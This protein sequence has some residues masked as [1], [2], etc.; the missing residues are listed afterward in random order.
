GGSELWTSDGTPAGTGQV[1]DINAGGA[2]SN[3]GIL[4]NVNGLLYFSADDGASGR[5]LWQSDGTLAGTVTVR[6]IYPGPTGSDPAFLVGMNNTLSC[7][8]T[9]PAHG[10]EWWAP[11]PVAPAPSD[12]LIGDFDG[13]RVLRYD[14]LTG[15]FVDTFVPRHSGGLNQPYGILFGP[16]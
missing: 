2:S 15:A 9:D 8:A 1:K 7:A 12:L 14:G 16:D 6:D 3:P 4:T 5:E 11:P 10:R 13:D